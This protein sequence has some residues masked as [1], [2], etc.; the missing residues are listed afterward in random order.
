MICRDDPETERVWSLIQTLNTT[1]PEPA[2]QA[3]ENLRTARRVVLCCCQL[4]P[5][6]SSSPV[7]V[8]G[9]PG[10]LIF[11]KFYLSGV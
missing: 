2:A 8:Q 6:H 9:P 1:F 7:P 3:I 4:K 5:Q 11:V 10:R